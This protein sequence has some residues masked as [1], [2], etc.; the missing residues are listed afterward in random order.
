MSDSNHE[1]L[2]SAI[3][4]KV[5]TYLKYFAEALASLIFIVGLIATPATPHLVARI[6]EER[7]PRWVFDG[8]GEETCPKSSKVLQADTRISLQIKNETNDYANDL[9]VVF[10]DV[11]EIVWLNVHYSLSKMNQDAGKHEETTQLE[12]GRLALFNLD[13]IPP[14]HS[15]NVMAVAYTKPLIWGDRVSVK[16]SKG[17]E[18]IR[19]EKISGFPLFIAK[20]I[21][22]IASVILSLFVIVGI[23]RMKKQ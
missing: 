13:P 9:E 8:E 16:S 17:V 23:R 4:K 2:W 21:E 3:P 11:K 10:S 6:D 12:D 18:I 22:I 14:G 7:T 15:I 19:E 20:N 1:F 5:V